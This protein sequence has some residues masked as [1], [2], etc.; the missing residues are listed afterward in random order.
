MKKILSSILACSIMMSL[1][2][3]CNNEQEKT[4]SVNTEQNEI[5]SGNSL[6]NSENTKGS[7]AEERTIIDVW[8]EDRHD[9]EYV[10]KMVAKY[11]EA[12]EDNIEIKLNLITEDYRNMLSLSY[13]GGTAPDVVGANSLPLNQ[14]ADTGILMPL[15]DFI[16][17]DP[18]FQKV[19]DPYSN[20]FEGSNVKDGKIYMVYSGMR[21]GVRVEYNKAILDQVGANEIPKKL[22]D[23]IN[24][25]KKITEAGKGEFYG[26]GFPSSSPFERLLEMSAQTSGIYFYDYV[27]G[28]FDFTGYRPILE[29]G[30]ELVKYAYPDQQGVDNMRALFAQGSFALWSNASQEAGVFT[31]QI[32]VTDFE[33][34]VAEVPT[35]DGEI[36]GALQITPSKAYG[37]VSN[38]DSIDD[39]WKVIHY[40]QSEEFLKGYLEGGFSLPITEYMNGVIDHSKTGR[41][42][43]FSLLEHESVYP[44]APLVNLQGDDYRTVLWNAVMGYVEIDDA[45]NDLNERYNAAL[46]ADIASGTVKRLV[47]TD[48]NPMKPNE[49]TVQYLDK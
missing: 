25:A 31:K 3:A 13:N 22:D 48:Y 2:A 14:F 4:T 39:A 26:I 7:K 37:I 29:K 27:N 9:Q 44:T 33:W 17:K 45:I 43:D 46:D 41:L 38:S 21:S 1:L 30:R 19:N 16:E 34:G 18:E 42:A 15:N 47:I 23:Y 36:K 10:E 11:N 24:L 5:Q 8:S 12:N 40:F 35:L 20:S 6:E 49:G 28:K 32:P